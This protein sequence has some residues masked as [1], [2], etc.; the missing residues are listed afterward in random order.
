MANDIGN[1]T[2]NYLLKAWRTN[3]TTYAVPSSTPPNRDGTNV[4]P[5]V[6]GDLVRPAISWV[7][8]TGI[9]MVSSGEV[10]FISGGGNAGSNAGSFSYLAF[11]DASSGGNF[12]GRCALTS[13]LAWVQG[14]PVKIAAGDISWDFT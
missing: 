9:V 5:P 11:Y 10:S 3:K 14:Q 8:P 7:D 1:Y 13:P 4:T 6:A 12:C 2:A